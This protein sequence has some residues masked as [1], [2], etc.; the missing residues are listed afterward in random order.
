MKMSVNI[1]RHI[2]AESFPNFPASRYFHRT[3]RCVDA[4]VGRWKN[5]LVSPL[6]RRSRSP[7][8]RATVTPSQPSPSAANSF[9][10]I[11]SLGLQDQRR[12]VCKE[13]QDLPISQHCRGKTCARRF[14]IAVTAPVTDDVT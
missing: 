12:M 5:K 7:T 3:M 8:S 9:F 11:N 6:R 2:G 1:D 10:A 4:K 13:W 14:S